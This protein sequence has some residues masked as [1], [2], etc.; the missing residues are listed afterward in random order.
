[1]RV[2]G[3]GVV[4]EPDAGHL[5]DRR[6]PVR[7]QVRATQA[8][9]HGLRG[10]A[11]RAGQGSRR[12]RVGDDVVGDGAPGEP[13][14]VL[15]PGELGRGRTPLEDERPVDEQVGHDAEV[16]PGRRPQAEADGTAALD[17]VG[18]ADHLLGHRV[19]EVVHAGHLRPL[20][21][22]RLG[23]PVRLAPPCQSRWSGARLRHTEA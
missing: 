17:D 18:L 6:G 2:G 23:V 21:H 12:E 4:H 8:V 3:L 15:H 7:R 9:A 19:G 11:E 1:V 13:D 10:D 22:P 20:V 14:Q 16:P 5:A